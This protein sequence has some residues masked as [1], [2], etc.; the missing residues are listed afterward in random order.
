MEG[1]AEIDDTLLHSHTLSILEPDVKLTLKSEEGCRA[2][3][4][5]GDEFL[6]PRFIAGSFVGS[7]MVK[8]R[9][10]DADYRAGRFPMIAR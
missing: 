9:Q 8:I 1:T 6:S 5:G 2:I 7:S 10:W 4:F 3:L